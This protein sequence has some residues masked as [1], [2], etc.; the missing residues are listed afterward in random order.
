MEF[1][2]ELGRKLSDREWADIKREIVNAPRLSVRQ[3]WKLTSHF[4]KMLEEKQA[5]ALEAAGRR[6][7]VTR[8]R[9]AQPG[10]IGGQKPSGKSPIG[11]GEGDKAQFIQDLIDKAG[12]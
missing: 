2:T 3:A 6:A 1:Q 7:P 9:P 4:E 11:L 10:S 5:K 8:P 12:G